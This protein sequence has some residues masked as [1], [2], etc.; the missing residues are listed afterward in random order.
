MKGA[1]PKKAANIMLFPY[2][3]KSSNGEKDTVIMKNNNVILVDK[4]VL[5]SSE[6][7]DGYYL[8]YNEKK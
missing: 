5:P 3:I 6:I 8:D 1:L 7:D 4:M 2:A